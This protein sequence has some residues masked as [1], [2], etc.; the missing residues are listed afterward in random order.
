VDFTED[1]A[2]QKLSRENVRKA[3]DFVCHI[4]QH[5]GPLSADP[6]LPKL[7]ESDFIMVKTPQQL[8]MEE[9]LCFQT[10]VPLRENTLGIGISIR[11]SARTGKISH[12]NSTMDLMSMRSFTKLKVRKSL[13]G[14]KFTHWFPLYFGETDTYKI[15][16]KEY[17]EKT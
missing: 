8:L 9:L 6:P 2:T 12:A 13:E 5:K 10:K 7:E 14:V 11:K 3:N 1:E 17:D 16:S 15:E 4:C